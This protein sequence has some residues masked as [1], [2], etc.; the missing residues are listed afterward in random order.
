D[1]KDIIYEDQFFMI[2]NKPAGIN[3]NQSPF[4]DIDCLSYGVQKYYDNKKI[5]Y[6]VNVIN[7]LDKP[8]SGLLFFAK[9]KEIEIFLHKF[10]NER[11]IRKLYLAIT[12]KFNLNKNEFLIRDTLTWKDKEKEAISYIKFLKEKDDKFYFIVYPMTGR[13]HQIRK[14]FKEYLKPII[15]DALYGNYNS[16]DRLEL[17]CIYY[18]FIHPVN[19]KIIEVRHIPDEYKCE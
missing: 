14:H 2:I 18:K 8:T 15:G 4:S 3:T 7:R 19:K 11:N 1:I 12:E 13:T 16:K 5:N 9:S 6:K 17:L 10:F